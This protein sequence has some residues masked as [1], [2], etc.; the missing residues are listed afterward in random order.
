ME[1]F[2]KPA[3]HG[4]SELEQGSKTAY[5]NNEKRLAEISSE[6]QA[7]LDAEDDDTV[8]ELIQERKR[9]RS[10]ND[11]IY[12]TNWQEANEINSSFDNTR[13]EQPA[14]LETEPAADSFAE[15]TFESTPGNDQEVIAELMAQLEDPEIDTL[16][17]LADHVRKI[18]TANKANPGYTTAGGAA[19]PLD[20]EKTAQTILA[21][22]GRNISHGAIQRAA[23]RIH[24]SEAMI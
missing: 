9:I 16:E 6:L 4:E 8:V 21:G 2:N 14:A 11:A 18:G 17:K 22:Y 13:A 15:A 23:N 19:G 3:P 7:A 20:A 12:S 5:E 10:E 1:S 24:E